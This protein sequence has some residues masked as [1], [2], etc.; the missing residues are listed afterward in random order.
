M[1]ACGIILPA[2]YTSSS[3]F[4]SLRFISDP[5]VNDI[6][7]KVTNVTGRNTQNRMMA[8][9]N[10]DE[11]MYINFC[12][13]NFFIFHF[14]IIMFFCNFQISR[15]CNPSSGVIGFINNDSDPR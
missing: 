3:N 9:N 10:E 7:K 11:N 5:Y 14:L 8:Q 2:P 4:L 15:K 6:G 12:S 13:T 1:T